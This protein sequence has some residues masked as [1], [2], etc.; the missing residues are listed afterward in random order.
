MKK[1]MLW[2]AVAALAANDLLPWPYRP[3]VLRALGCNVHPT[4]VIHAGLR[5][6]SPRLEIG[7]GAFLNY[8]CLLDNQ[9]AHITIGE[10]AFLAPGVAVLTT[11]HEPGS[12]EQRA[13]HLRCLATS[14]GNGAWIGARA[15][16]LPGVS[17]GD[18]AIVGAGAVVTRSVAAGATVTGVPARP[19]D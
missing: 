12:H 9:E 11:T 15:T 7:A 6:L 4:A 5:V 13:G 16:I 19:A 8:D 14:V 2:R 10:R 3:R 18:G 1:T 17:V